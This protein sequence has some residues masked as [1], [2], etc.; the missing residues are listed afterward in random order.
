MNHQIKQKQVISEIEAQILQARL[1]FSTIR[2]VSDFDEDPRMCLTSVHFPKASLLHV[3]QQEIIAPLKVM[4]SKMYAYSDDSL[5]MTIK[6][7]KTAADPQTFSNQD[8][9]TAQEVFSK[10]MPKHGAF[11]VNF[12]KLLLFPASIALIG[13]TAPELD[14]IILDLDTQLAAAQIPDDKTY[15][16]NRY[17]FSNMTLAR[18]QEVLSNDFVQEVARISEK[19]PLII[20]TPYMVDSVTLLKANAVMKKRQIIQTF[21]LGLPNPGIA[22]VD[23]VLQ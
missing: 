16:N 12:Y 21:R 6:N 20:T 10:T 23:T 3:I 5:H 17:F 19:I 14:S 1:Q 13:T 11:T 7:I 8:M 15:V 22:P 2:P 4:N 18:F 9:V